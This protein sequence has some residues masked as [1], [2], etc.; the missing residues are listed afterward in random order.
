MRAG[1]RAI[2]EG[3]GPAHVFRACRNMIWASFQYNPGHCSKKVTYLRLDPLFIPAGC[4]H[5]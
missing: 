2:V 4:L 3:T 5:L 1:V